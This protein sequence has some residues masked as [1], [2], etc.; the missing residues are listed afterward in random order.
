M[1]PV[2]PLPSVVALCLAVASTYLIAKCFSPPLSNQGR[3][4][5]IDG[6]RG[7]L[8]FFVFL[9]HSSIWYFFLRT[10]KWAIPPSNLYT[11]FGQGS[12]ALFFMITGFL[13]FSKILDAKE[14]PIDWAK[15][16]MSRVMRLTPLYIFATAILFFIVGMVTK[17]QLADP[18]LKLA[19]NVVRWLGFTLLGAPHLNGYMHTSNIIAGVTW[20]MQYEWLFY[21]SLPFLALV[22]RIVPPVSCLIFCGLLVLALSTQRPHALHLLTFSGGIAA[23]FFVRF[24]SIRTICAQRSASFVVLG[25]LV[26]TFTMFRETYGAMPLFLLSIAFMMM[27]CGNNIFGILSSPISRILGDMGYSIYLLHGILLFV[28]FNFMVGVQEAKHLTA[29]HHWWLVILMSP[30][31]IFISYATF[32]FIEKPAMAHTNTVMA[33]IRKRKS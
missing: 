23:A 18:P 11:N 17:W 25:L 7:Y 9:H 1:S 33:W 16:F 5:S 31:L 24:S 27:A 22:V 8:A 3:F 32:R 19:I 10:G 13:F 28:T 15:L 4:V 2:S 6:L 26:Y 30:I 21:F 29:S 20:S 14:R 12:V